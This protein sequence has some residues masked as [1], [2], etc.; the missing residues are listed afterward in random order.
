MAST[1]VAGFVTVTVN[2]AVPPGSGSVDGAADLAT[3]TV[4]FT[5]VTVTVKETVPPV[6]GRALGE[7]GLSVTILGAMLRIVTGAP[8]VAGGVALPSL[9]LATAVTVSSW[10]VPALP[11]TVLVNEQ[12]YWPPMAMG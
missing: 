2:V 10:F 7:A 4:G 8:S 9:S 3:R 12:V 6:S 11:E 5:S 1:A